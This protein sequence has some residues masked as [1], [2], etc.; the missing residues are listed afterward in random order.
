MSLHDTDFKPVSILD[1]L[2][3]VMPC[4]RKERLQWHTRAMLPYVNMTYKTIEILVPAML[5]TPPSMEYAQKCSVAEDK[6]LYFLTEK[7]R[8]GFGLQ[9]HCPVKVEYKKDALKE[10]VFMMSNP[11]RKAW[12]NTFIPQIISE[13]FSEISSNWRWIGNFGR[14]C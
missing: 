1:F 2:K 13:F 9:S 3:I 7:D 6:L 5:N 10:R 8:L 12:P 11:F 4:N 14:L